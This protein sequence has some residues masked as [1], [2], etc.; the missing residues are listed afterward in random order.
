MFVFYIEVED[1]SMVISVLFVVVVVV[2]VFD[3]PV[4]VYKFINNPK[5]AQEDTNHRRF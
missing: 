4:H 2:L 3:Q 1:Y 5:R